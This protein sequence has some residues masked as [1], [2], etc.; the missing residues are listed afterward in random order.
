MSG[1]SLILHPKD[2]AVIFIEFQNEFTTEGGGLYEA[3]KGCMEATGTLTHA[4]AVL[5]AA[6]STGCT[7]VHCPISFQK[8]HFEI[9]NSPYGILAPIKNGQL[10]KANEWSSTICDEMK[11][12]EGDLIC[13]GKSGLCGF[14]S[15][16]L[17]FI[18]RQNKIRN[19]V[20]CGFLTNCC[21]ESTMRTAY[22]KGYRVYTLKDCCF[23]TSIEAQEAA[24][25][26]TF[27]MFSFLLKS[28]VRKSYLHM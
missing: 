7:I 3:V 22:E 21:V 27:G 20:L 5:E 16:N 9:S 23:A 13:I 8:G 6:R 2:T 17:D 14:A 1:D 12:V 24:Y 10:F 25:Q 26:H 15:T 11:P 4:K 28:A 19:V 18:L